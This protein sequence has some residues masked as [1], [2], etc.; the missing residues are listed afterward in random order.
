MR[1][2][3]IVRAAYFAFGWFDFYSGIMRLDVFLKLSRLIPRR[4]LAQEFC[5]AGLIEVNGA[6]AKSSKE[7]KVG[8]T[9]RIRRRTRET[10]VLV[11]A[12]PDKK[13]LSKDLAVS[14]YKIVSEEKLPDD[15]L[16]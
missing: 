15:G 16:S 6:A 10:S 5:D 3:G 9:I 1:A 8:D 13:Q 11:E 14:L 12:V 4:S 2:F 7:I